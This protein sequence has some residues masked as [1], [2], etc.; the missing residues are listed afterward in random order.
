[1]FCLMLSACGCGLLFPT[2]CNPDIDIPAYIYVEKVVLTTTLSEQGT[3]SAKIPNIWVSVNGQNIGTYQLPALIPVVASGK[4]N[5]T[6]EAGIK[7]NG[8]SAQRPAYPLFKPYTTSITLSKDKVDTI[9]PSFTYQD[10][11]KIPLMEDFESA[12]LKF[13]P[14]TGS[15]PLEKTQDSS[16]L[17]SYAN[18]ANR[19]SGII[20]LPY[21]DTVP[22]FEI[23]TTA[24][25]YL[26]P[27]TATDCFIEI[28][29]SF[30]Q[31]VE[32]G[33]YCHSAYQTR[34]VPIMIVKGQENPQWD[35]I[36]VNL[37]DEIG[38]AYSQTQMTHFDIYMKSSVPVGKTARY[39]FDN[40][41]IVYW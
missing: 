21:A 36:Y 26:T 37:T 27:Q 40:I 38:S 5:I 9:S 33:L 35:K 14:E 25:L 19:F 24:P 8:L 12:G 28:N 22:F 4:T 18:E 7:L 16:L 13:S 17:F 11:V 3:A 31:D 2:A 34:Q 32:I 30:S 10:N 39:L 23:K 20:T 6:I 29:Y 41:K 15:A 1:M